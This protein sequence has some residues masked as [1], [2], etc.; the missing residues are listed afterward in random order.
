MKNLLF[1]ILLF[2]IPCHAA[3][4]TFVYQ[5]EVSG[6]FCSVCSSHVK[7]A[8][9]T[10]QGVQDVKIKIAPE[11]QLPKLTLTATTDRLTRED[12]VKALGDKAKDFD[13]RSLKLV[14]PSS[15]TPTR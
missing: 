15:A 8:L 12:A 10:I 6:V 4:P 2:V 9:M 7:A 1:T 14:Q 3:D 11:G 5:G 13:I